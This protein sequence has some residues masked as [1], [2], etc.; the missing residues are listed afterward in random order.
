MYLQ[1]KN[2]GVSNAPSLDVFVY[3]PISYTKP[4]SSE[5][6]KLI[7]LN[8]GSTEGNFDGQKIE[9]HW[10]EIDSDRTTFNLNNLLTERDVFSKNDKYSQNG[11]TNSTISLECGS[12]ADVHCIAGN[13]TIPHLL[14]NSKMFIS[15]HFDIDMKKVCEVTSGE[16]NTFL[17]IRTVAAL[18][19]T[20]D[21]NK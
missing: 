16:S 19:R 6:Q 3:L 9:I 18:K 7:T 5:T 8:E 14:I 12:S 10:N 20:F 4:G 2:N 17:E 11:K 1:I 21:F 15:L 13:F